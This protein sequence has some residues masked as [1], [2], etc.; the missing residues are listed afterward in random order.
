[1]TCFV[2][3]SGPKSEALD[4]FVGRFEHE[5][6]RMKNRVG[7]GWFERLR[8]DIQLVLPDNEELW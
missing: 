1:M 5:F 2:E 8:G 3:K 7:K 4:V 6:P